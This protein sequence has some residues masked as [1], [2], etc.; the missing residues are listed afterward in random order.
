MIKLTKY[1]EVFIE[2]LNEPEVIGV[3][4]PDGCVLSI[5]MIDDDE[6]GIFHQYSDEGKLCLWS[7][8]IERHRKGENETD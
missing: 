5:E 2:P 7:S 4:L 6:I 3:R 1:V 8:T